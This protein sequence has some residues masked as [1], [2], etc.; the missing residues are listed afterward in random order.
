MTLCARLRWSRLKDG[1]LFDLEML[2]PRE[3]DTTAFQRKFGGDRI[4][5]LD[6]PAL[7]KP[8]NHVKGQNVQDRLLEMFMLDQPFLGR[9]WL[10]Y[11][12]KDKKRRDAAEQDESESGTFQVAFF[13]LSGPGLEEVSIAECLDWAVPFGPNANQ[14][15]CKANA[16]LDLAAS[17]TRPTLT[18]EP[19]Q[20]FVGVDD[21]YA[22]NMPDDNTYNDPDLFF[23]HLFDREKP[24]EMSDGCCAISVRAMQKVQDLL[25]LD[26][27][28]SVVQARIFGAKGIWYISASNDGEDPTPDDVWIKISKTQVKAKHDKQD[29]I[30]DAELR[31]LNVVNYSHPAKRSLLYPGFIPI[32][33]DRGVPAQVILD[34]AR[35]QIEIDG[36]NYLE[37]IK[38]IRGLYRWVNTMKDVSGTRSRNG[39]IPMQA[40]LPCA[41]DERVLQ[42]V[43]AGFEPA[44]CAFLK[45]EVLDVGEYVFKLEARQ[46]K[47]H[48]NQSTSLIGICDPTGTLKPGEVHILLSSAFKDNDT[49]QSRSTLHGLEVLIARNPSLRNSDIQKAR[50][51]FCPE[52]AHLYDVVVFSAQG[53]RPLASKLSGGDYDGD[54]FW[55]TWQESLVQPFMNAPAPWAPRDYQVF[56]LTKDKVT[57][58][59][60][61]VGPNQTQAALNARGPMT[62]SRGARS[63]ALIPGQDSHD[64]KHLDAQARKWIQRSTADRMQQ[65]YLGVVTLL[66]GKLTYAENDIS[67]E[68]ADMLVD[69]HDH[70]VDADKQGLRYTEDSYT[71]FKRAVGIPSYLPEPAYRVFTGNAEKEDG[72]KPSTKSPPTPNPRN[73]V[74]QMYFGIVEPEVQKAIK[75][76]RATMKYAKSLDADLTALYEDLL[77]SQSS[78][79]QEELL[80]LKFALSD[81]REQWSL[82]MRKYHSEGR[83]RNDWGDC[84]QQ[85]RDTY[86][87]IMPNN[88]DSDTVIEWLRKRGRSFTGWEEIK[89]SALS[90][91]QHGSDGSLMFSIAGTELC[92]L[93]AQA[94]PPEKMRSVRLEIYLLLKPHKRKIEDEL[95]EIG[96]DEEAENEYDHEADFDVGESLFDGVKVAIDDAGP[97]AMKAEPITPSKPPSRKRKLNDLHDVRRNG[98]GPPPVLSSS[99]SDWLV[100]RPPGKPRTRRHDWQEA[101]GV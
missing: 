96:L 100:D 64:V 99:P 2:P 95:K 18:F 101:E 93:K 1:P 42:L 38:D 40:G 57:L 83:K 54:T 91:L 68:K 35:H 72:T 32:L 24:L 15:A 26:Y 56:G 86:L 41:T 34:I 71:N 36:N 7:N 67:S 63:D 31:T 43:G 8:P 22:Q 44:D 61:L 87:E 98:Q 25:G 90:R 62:R 23:P 14:A 39:G 28:P 19:H 13:A 88:T 53:P 33:L 89:A 27:L 3:E 16:R 52:L 70:L 58:R 79:I 66:H 92:H 30:D 49:G 73:V 82:G 77:H 85:C 6:L 50:A 4:M 37:A 21:Q 60:I 59:D 51:R 9:K 47:I 76:A 45:K 20:M 65:Q 84:I 55:V 17:R 11:H 94:Q 10:Q 97:G 75:Q 69:L 48:L 46:F 74:D 5:V 80:V 78:I 12:V 29:M 81:M